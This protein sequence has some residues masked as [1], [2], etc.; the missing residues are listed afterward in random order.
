MHEVTDNIRKELNIPRY[1]IDDDTSLS[2][3][4]DPESYN[5][6]GTDEALEKYMSPDYKPNARHHH[7]NMNANAGMSGTLETSI[8][9]RASKVSTEQSV[10]SYPFKS[11]EEDE[12]YSTIRSDMNNTTNLSDTQTLK[13]Y[14]MS[15]N[16]QEELEE[17]EV[18]GTAEE[19]EV[20][21]TAEEGEVNIRAEVGEVNARPEHVNVQTELMKVNVKAEQR[22]L[23][24]STTDNSVRV[25]EDEEE[26]DDD[27]Y[28]DDYE[29]DGDDEEEDG[30]LTTEQTATYRTDD[31]DF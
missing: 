3:T 10:D 9:S 2:M 17:G 26:D 7:D 20:N 19:G 11:T 22:N 29:D 16:E 6:N 8:K 30:P 21:G 24:A 14:Q 31:D 15:I 4:Q 27:I 25:T 23:N 1:D 18:D 13:T 12:I 28:D 5:H